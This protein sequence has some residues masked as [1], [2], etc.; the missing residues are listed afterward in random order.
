[1]GVKKGHRNFPVWWN[2]YL[3]ARYSHLSDLWIL[4]ELFALYFRDPYELWKAAYATF[5]PPEVKHLLFKTE[6]YCDLLLSTALDKTS[7]YKFAQGCD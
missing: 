6:I 7:L 1:M 3:I 4:F 5:F 2:L